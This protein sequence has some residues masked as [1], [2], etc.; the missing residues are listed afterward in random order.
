M[1]AAADIR[2]PRP[3]KEQFAE[4]LRRVEKLSPA[5]V[6]LASAMKVLRDPQSDIRSIA[7]LVG[8]DPALA[9]DIIRCSNS[10]YYRG[11]NSANI[12]EAVQKIG[13]GETMRLLNLA[14]ARIVS[15]RDLCC[16]G[17]QGSDYWAESLFNGI[18]MRALAV[19]SGQVDAEEAYTVGLLRFIGRLAVDQTINVLKWGIF[20][21]GTDTIT[22]WEQKTIGM[23]QAEAGEMLLRTWKFSERIAR[24]VGV[25]DDP[26]APVDGNWYAE[27]LHFASL[28]LPQGVG[29]PFLPSVGPI[30]GTTPVGAEFM[31]RCELSTATVDRLLRETSQS[32]DEVRANFGV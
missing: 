15:G 28:L 7:A 11:A 13:I 32:Y 26:V 21:D 24:A 25:Q 4:A 29:T 17:I 31:E 14:V 27:A 8:R 9:A 6:I 16:Y 3:S 23:T 22:H 18:F 5:P 30:W 19:E 20:W 1:E 10:V 12:G 2:G